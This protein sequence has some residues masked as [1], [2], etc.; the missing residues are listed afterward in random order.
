MS[1]HQDFIVV[2]LM[3]VQKITAVPK[4]SY[5]QVLRLGKHNRNC[6]KL[7]NF[8]NLVLLEGSTFHLKD[9]KK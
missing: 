5:L 6:E 1:S 2:A 8:Q 9:K 4:L 7:F 3:Q